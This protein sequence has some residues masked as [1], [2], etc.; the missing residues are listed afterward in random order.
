MRQKNV[1]ILGTGVYLPKR[2]VTSKELDE[3][4]GLP[5][6]TVERTSGVVQRRYADISTESQSKMGAFAAMAALENAQM[7]YEDIDAIISCGGSF[8]Q[9]IPCTAALIQRALGKEDSGT[10]CF[11]VNTTCLGFVNA[12]D[13]VSCLIATKRYRNVLLIASEMA[14]AGINE[15]HLESFSLFGDGAVCAVVGPT[16]ENETSKVLNAHLMTFSS[17]ADY[18]SVKGGGTQLNV[19]Q[20]KNLNDIPV[21]K[22]LF[23]MDGRKVFRAAAETIP[24]FVEKLLQPMQTTIQD[25]KWIIP[26]Q[27]SQ[28]GMELVRRRLGV[29]PD[30]WVSIIENHGNMIAASIPLALHIAIQDKR[31]QRGDRVLLIGT[32]A[33]LS[34]GGVAL[35]Y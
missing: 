23:H 4:Q 35:E 10:A 17:G 28:S 9:P 30:H 18:C 3:K 13:L 2:I 29:S 21:E 25:F 15:S 16:P 32:S 12:L 34:I 1:K 8:E 20:F 19:K 22:F 7:K 26:H 33:G 31:I 14:S 5:L 11:D 6:G 24:K 27:A